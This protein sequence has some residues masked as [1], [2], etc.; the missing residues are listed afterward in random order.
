MKESN[1]ALHAI[2][3]KRSFVLIRRKKSG[4][5]KRKN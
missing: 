5:V 1:N 3:E 4:R 2:K